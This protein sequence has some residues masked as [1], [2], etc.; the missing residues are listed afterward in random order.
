L[1]FFQL[2]NLFHRSSKN[3][4][5]FI[6]WHEIQIARQLVFDFIVNVKLVRLVGLV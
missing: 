6:Q 2:M 3:S 1:L 5:N 4:L